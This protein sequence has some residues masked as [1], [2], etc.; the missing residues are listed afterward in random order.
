[1]SADN[2]GTCPKCESERNKTKSLYGKIPEDEY[3][4]LIEKQKVDNRQSLREDYELFTDKTGKFV[5][6]YKCL[7][8]KCEFEFNFKYT[9]ILQ[10]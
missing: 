1:M 2:W 5:V 7:C 10:F 4:K 8:T 9:E 3:L 6:S